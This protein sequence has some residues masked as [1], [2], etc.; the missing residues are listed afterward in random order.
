MPRAGAV[1]RSMT[2]NSI[3]YQYDILSEPSVQHVEAETVAEDARHIIHNCIT[4]MMVSPE[5]AGTTDDTPPASRTTPPTIPSQLP[6]DLLVQNRMTILHL[7]QSNA[8]AP[9]LLT[10]SA[11]GELLLAPTLS[12][13]P[14]AG[15]MAGYFSNQPPSP[16]SAAQIPTWLREYLIKELNVR[17]HGPP[18]NC[19]AFYSRLLD[20]R[21]DFGLNHTVRTAEGALAFAVISLRYALDELRSF[22][23][24]KY[25]SKETYGDE[26]RVV[27]RNVERM[28]GCPGEDMGVELR[29][30]VELAGMGAAMK[31]AL[32][33]GLKRLVVGPYTRLVER[34]E[35]VSKAL[36]IE[37]D[38]VDAEAEKDEGGVVDTPDS[39]ISG[40]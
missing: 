35:L 20:S 15:T 24:A 29:L 14:D 33:E 32:V 13:D 34:L 31:E 7:E 17:G 2:R 25:V 21:E 5:P 28:V 19:R 1:T 12:P 26:V 10:I 27:V 37:L 30:L 39:G 18:A 8:L 3:A 40:C 11:T 22:I 36:R 16:N 6:K 38:R 9:G 23:A 4:Y